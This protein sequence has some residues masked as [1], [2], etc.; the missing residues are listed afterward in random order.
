MII[1]HFVILIQKLCYCIRQKPSNIPLLWDNVTHVIQQMQTYS[2]V[3]N[4]FQEIPNVI[5]LNR[6]LTGWTP[7]VTASRGCFR[8]DLQETEVD[9]LKTFKVIFEILDEDDSD[10][11]LEMISDESF[12]SS[13]FSVMAS[14]DKSMRMEDATEPVAFLPSNRNST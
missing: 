4:C 7:Q 14:M 5:E 8:R 11:L 6:L 13:A 10:T 9:L 2:N 12:T 1:S 3:D